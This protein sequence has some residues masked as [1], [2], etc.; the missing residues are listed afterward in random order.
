[1]PSCQLAIFLAVCPS[2]RLP[3]QCP[4]GAPP[5][6]ASARQASAAA[7][8]HTSVAVLYFA[9]RD[10][11][12]AYLADGLTEDVTTLLSR[13]GGLTVKPSSS[14]RL[15][16]RRQPDADPRAL[17]RSLAVRYVVQASLRR[18]TDRVRLNVQLIE[19]GTDVSIW[20]ETYDR[21]AQGLLDLPAQ[22][23]TEI[24]NRVG[25]V[26]P[27]T[28]PATTTVWRTTNPAALDHFRR[29]NRFLAGREQL[30]SA[31]NEYRHAAR[32]DPRFASAV[33]RSAYTLAL[34]HSFGGPQSDVVRGLELAGAALGI[35]STNSDAWM[36]LGYLRAFANRKTLEGSTEAFERAITLDSM[37][38]EA[39]H[40][41]GQVLQ[42]LGDEAGAVRALGRALAIEPARAISLS[43]MG[44]AFKRDAARMLQLLDS[45]LAVAAAPLAV[46]HGYR[47][48]ALLMLHQ[49]DLALR[50]LDALEPRFAAL[51]PTAAF[52]TVAY[53][54]RGDS[55]RA[56]ETARDFLP[57]RTDGGYAGL[58]AMLALGDTAA[59]LQH[60]EHIPAAEQDA[61]MWNILRSPWF[62]GLR[63]NPRFMAVYRAS[64]PPAARAP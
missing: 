3:A 51:M 52:R 31:F 57:P 19:A 11:D 14:V 41:Y 8:A 53:A 21:T 36:A 47:V 22:L 25:G 59:A 43:D 56:R 6:C 20:G 10:S 2:A 1:L 42:W 63:D 7:L 32:L 12:D 45:A 38:A 13:R 48:M 4:N 58:Y 34:Q 54:M 61:M 18:T 23:A 5:P 16:Q 39:W 60:L 29:G 35:D 40:Q 17:G 26:S 9:A 24:A 33:A 55:S 37:N 49:P 46:T 44:M 62:D 64:R 28:R 30:D 50:Q 27:G 15:A